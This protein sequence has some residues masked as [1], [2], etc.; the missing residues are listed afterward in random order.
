MG[1]S[2]GCLFLKLDE[3]ILFISIIYNNV[4]EV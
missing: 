1:K 2:G 4:E 3:E